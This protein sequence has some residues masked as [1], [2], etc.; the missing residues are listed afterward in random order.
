MIIRCLLQTDVQR[1]VT[2]TK[3]KQASLDRT[4]RPEIKKQNKTKTETHSNSIYQ[5]AIVE[6]S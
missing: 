4:E 6:G 1:L 3:C 2:K 5:E